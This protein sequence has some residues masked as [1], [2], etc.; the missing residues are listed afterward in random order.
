M[1]LQRDY[2]LPNTSLIVSG[3]YHIVTDVS[4][5]KRNNN[6][7]EPVKPVDDIV[8]PEP[9]YDN[10]PQGRQMTDEE[11]LSTIPTNSIQTGSFD[12]SQTDDL[13]VYW[14]NGY[15]SRIAISVYASK[16]ARDEGKNPIAVLGYDTNRIEPNVQLGTKGLDAKI[17]FKTNM[18]SEDNIFTQAYN[19]LKTTDYYSSSID[20]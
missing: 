19:Y 4:V 2:I 17:I 9:I 18:E 3:A 12:I 15:T 1:A 6:V 13:S 8:Q 16:D 10:L 11:K 20:I 14:E 5:N 7:P